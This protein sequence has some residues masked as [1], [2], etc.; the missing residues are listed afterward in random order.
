MA[1]FNI[2]VGAAE[3]LTNIQH[4][5]VLKKEELSAGTV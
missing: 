1:A 3:R 5:D 2:A 4:A